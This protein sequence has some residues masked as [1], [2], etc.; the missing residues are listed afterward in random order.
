MNS[1]SSIYNGCYHIS[2]FILYYIL[3]FRIRLQSRLVASV[4][5]LLCA[6]PC[7]NLPCINPSFVLPTEKAPISTGHDCPHAMQELLDSLIH[8]LIRD[9]AGMCHDSP[10]SDSRAPSSLLLC[11]VPRG[12]SEE[13]L[14]RLA[15]LPPLLTMPCSCN[16]AHPHTYLLSTMLTQWSIVCANLGTYGI[17]GYTSPGHAPAPLLTHTHTCSDSRLC[18]PLQQLVVLYWPGH[19][20]TATAHNPNLVYCLCQL[21]TCGITVYTKSGASGL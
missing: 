16:P 17:T 21:G 20:A 2:L 11:D 18:Y 10:G 3:H 1:S 15:A 13:F 9:S 7:V 4:V 8:R 14:C 5:S 6:R 12:A 19:L